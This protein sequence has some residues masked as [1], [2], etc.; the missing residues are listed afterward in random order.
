MQVSHEL[1]P[2]DSELWKQQKSITAVRLDL[3]WAGNPKQQR[4]QE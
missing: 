2:M 4:N 1:L 3:I